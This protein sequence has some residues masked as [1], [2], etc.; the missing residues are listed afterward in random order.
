MNKIQK[1]IQ[2][3]NIELKELTLEEGDIEYIGTRLKHIREELKKENKVFEKRNV[4]KITEISN[5]KI[6]RIEKG[7]HS[8]YKDVIKLINLYRI[9]GYNPLWILTKNNIF[10][11][12]KEGLNP[13]VILN[14]NTASNASLT[15]EK[16]IKKTQEDLSNALKNFKKHM[17]IT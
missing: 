2:R 6:Y 1:E 12:K 11:P 9:E 13:E 17:K 5:T 15:L 7:E 4:V 10:I 14:K 8:S 3:L 16:E